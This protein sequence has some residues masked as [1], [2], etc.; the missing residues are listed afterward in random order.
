M[1]NGK[2]EYEPIGS[3][4]QRRAKMQIKKTVNR[5]KKNF[6][7]KI[8]KIEKQGNKGWILPSKLDENWAS[9]VKVDLNNR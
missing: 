5:L 7:R 6:N 8:K 3:Y 4:S 1:E 9:V 2:M